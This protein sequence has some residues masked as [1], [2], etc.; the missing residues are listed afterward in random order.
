MILVDTSI[1]VARQPIVDIDGNL[2]AYELLYRNSDENSYPNVNPDKATM[3]VLINTFLTIGADVVVGQQLSFV[4]FTGTLLAQDI[5]SQM[6][7]K[8]I[9]IEVLE[10]VE[11]TP[12]LISRLQEL[13]ELGFKVAMDDFILG[14]Q[15]EVHRNLFELVDFVKV[16]F[17]NSTK[18]QRKKIETFTKEFTGIC[19]LAEKIETTAQFEEAKASGYQLFQ[20]YF[21]SK[22]EIIKGTEIPSNLNF[23]LEIIQKF[24]TE[25]PNV[26]EIAALISRDVS[27][28]YRLL[29]LINTHGFKREKEITSITQAIVTVG[30]EGT[31]KWLFALALREV[32][33][34]N[35]RGKAKA[36][37]Q[38]SLIRAKLCE[39][40]A[41][42][43]KKDNP[44]EYFIAGMFS[45]I[46]AIL[47]REVDEILP[48]ISLSDKVYKTLKREQTDLMP[49]IL[50]AESIEKLD[51]ERTQILADEIGMNLSE[52]SEC[53]LIAAKW[54]QQIN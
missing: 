49:F 54:V 31:K 4:N 29:R 51:I 36:L 3:A 25:S 18:E 13:R 45:L 2:F 8:R 24:S 50:I 46:D 19:L 35:G 38:N 52:V 23:H 10:D 30:L 37:V 12:S 43:L 1:F 15:Y 6:D 26:A 9:V 27:L 28:T 17:I 22:P 14:K 47:R 48:Q 11:I 34:G 42:H 53:S 21:F 41:I 44:D 39:L 33:E 40:L 7:A 16:D 32:G 20:G 5:F